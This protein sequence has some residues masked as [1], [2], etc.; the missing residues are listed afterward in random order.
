[1]H[2]QAAPPAAP[3]STPDPVPLD[4]AISFLKKRDGIDKVL[5]LIRYTAKLAL[6]TTHAPIV[7]TRAV[8]F[9]G[10][11]GAPSW[12][13]SPAYQPRP[14]SF[15]TPAR[16]S[17]LESSIGDARKA[18][19]L[20]KWLQGVAGFW[21]VGAM[22]ALSGS[23]GLSPALAALAALGD[24]CY[25]FLEQGT[26]LV[27]ARVAPA[28]YGPGIMRASATAELVSYLGSSGLALVTLDGLNL[29]EVALRRELAAA[30]LAWPG[31]NIPALLAELEAMRAKRLTLRLA[32]LQDA[33]D[34][35]LA[36]T[37]LRKSGR[38]GLL[39]S[40]PLLAVAGL[41]SALLGT[42]KVWLATVKGAA[43]DAA[44]KKKG[45]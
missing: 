31:E 37:D 17:A 24:A 13:T 1:M 28:E 39:D 33:C 12:P 26:W 14:S 25:F 7:A 42:R 21:E 40:K 4:L 8:A 9:A 38:G 3:A 41:V 35:L 18:Y 34:A 6:V 27:R 22:E 11:G 15:L 36:T 5:K 32:L 16:L 10:A 45:V 19:R 29:R 44:R 23:R 43:E 20:G 30:R 2:A